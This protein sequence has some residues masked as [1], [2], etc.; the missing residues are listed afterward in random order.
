MAGRGYDFKIIYNNYLV[1]INGEIWGLKTMTKLQPVAVSTMGNN[2]KNEPMY[3]QYV[4]TACINGKNKPLIIA[5]EVAKAF[6]ENTWINPDG[7][8]FKPGEE[9]VDHIDGNTANNHYKNLRWVSR[10]WNSS[11]GSNVRRVRDIDTDIIY[12]S[13]KEC[14]RELG[15]DIGNLCSVCRGRYKYMTI[16]GVKRHFEYI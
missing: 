7:T 9:V 3:L 6:V 11:N 5:R 15:I 10:K 14:S 1:R 2:K 4:C 8:P 13:A 12:K 16:N